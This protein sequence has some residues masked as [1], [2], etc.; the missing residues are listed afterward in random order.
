MQLVLTP[1]LVIEAYKQG[2][3]PMAY[4]TGSPLIHW[5]RPERRGQLS[6]PQV[7]I[8]R[9]LKDSLK[10]APYD[11]RIDT[12]FSD[13]VA[14]CAAPGPKRPESWINQPI[15]DVFCELQARG[16]A[17]SVECWHDAQ[18]IGGVYGLA[19]GQAFF[20]ESMFFKKRDASKIALMHL[21]ARLWRGGF[22]L[23]DTQFVN[24]HLKKFGAFEISNEDYQAVLCDAVARDAD[25]ELAGLVEETILK[26]YL[27]FRENPYRHCERIK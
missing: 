25:F 7:H 6:I 21:I 15:M 26:D 17:H 13:V 2:L 22:T 1:E 12:A 8:P 16:H 3:F 18:L 11:V 5:L 4:S 27:K 20:A 24:P 9:R 19:V 23:L 14:A 10:A